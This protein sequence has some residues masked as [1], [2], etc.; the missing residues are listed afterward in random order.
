MPLTDAACRT[1][2]PQDKPYKLADGGGMFLLVNPSGSKWWRLKYRFAGKE[3][4]LS[5]GTYPEI[6]LRDARDQRED[7]RRLLAAG[8]D[9]SADRKAQEEAKAAA[10]A[11]SFEAVAREWIS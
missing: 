4:L 9:P 1:A 10:A 3:K 6:G 5:L 2:K 11:N 8:I 7:M